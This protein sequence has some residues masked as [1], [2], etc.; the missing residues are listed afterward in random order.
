MA[1]ELNNNA[2]GTENNNQEAAKKEK[3]TLKQKRADFAEKHPK[4]T[5]GAKTAGK[6][7]RELAGV[8][9]KAAVAGAA[10]MAVFN[11]RKSET[12]HAEN[13]DALECNDYKLI[14]E[15]AAEVEEASAMDEEPANVE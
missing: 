15:P 9:V 11:I 12:I 5:K 13:D 7:C 14:E 6:A 2:N 1:K 10:I 8:A 3:K 4:I